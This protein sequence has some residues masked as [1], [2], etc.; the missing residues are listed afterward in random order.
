MVA[1]LGNVLYWFFSGAGFLPFIVL[2]AVWH[3]GDVPTRLIVVCIA[4]SVL[5]WLFGRASLYVLAGR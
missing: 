5:I 1:R 3:N 2:A 4:A